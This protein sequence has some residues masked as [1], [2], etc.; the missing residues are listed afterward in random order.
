MKTLALR[1][2]AS[3]DPIHPRR[4]ISSWTLLT[5]LCIFMMMRFKVR[6]WESMKFFDFQIFW[7]SKTKNTDKYGDFFIR[8]MQKLNFPRISNS[9]VYVKL[10]REK[11]WELREFKRERERGKRTSTREDDALSSLRGQ[12]RAVVKFIVVVELVSLFLV[13]RPR[14]RP[15]AWVLCVYFV[16]GECQL[17]CYTS[18]RFGLSKYPIFMRFL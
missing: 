6:W 8:K 1:W 11:I 18:A 9:W 3:I 10:R 4:H 15:Y 2:L 17:Y 5:R 14:T 7:T 16:C 12:E 13:V